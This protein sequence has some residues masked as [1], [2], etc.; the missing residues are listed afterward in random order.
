MHEP[1]GDR[2]P[3]RRRRL[4]LLLVSVVFVLVVAGG[5]QITRSP[6][7]DVDRVELRGARHT[8]AAEVLGVAGLG[9]GAFMS[10]VDETAAARRV[11]GLPWVRSARV[12][13]QW[14]NTVVVTVRERTPVASVSRLGKW[15]LVDA[16]GRVLAIA[17]APWPGTPRIEGV[18]RVPPP[19]R[20][21]G[22]GGRAAVRVARAL[23][24]TMAERLTAVLAR[25]T[26]VDLQ[27]RSA[28]VRLGAAERVHEKL[29]TLE[30]LLARADLQS[31]SVIDVRAPASPILIR[32]P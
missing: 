15:A 6:L 12:R 2:P 10:S 11:A 1:T 21:L 7:L 20:R 9:D 17:A 31:V 18:P 30:T 5:W 13:R 4:R 24:P 23:P 26:D 14:P 3:E 16:E 27:L 32:K 28:T 25:G 8:V 22:P 29:V 19:G